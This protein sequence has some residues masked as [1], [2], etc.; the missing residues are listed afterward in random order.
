MTEGVF[1][2]L[3]AGVVV[4]IGLGVLLVHIVQRGR[5]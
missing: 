1:V 3:C 5:P 4:G 2:A